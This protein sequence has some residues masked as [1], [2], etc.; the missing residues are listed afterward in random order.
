VVKISDQA[1]A[2]TGLRHHEAAAAGFDPVTVESAA[3]DHKACY[4]GSHRTTMRVTSDRATG[5]LPGMQVF[6]KRA[7]IAER[8]DI[9]ASAIYGTVTVDPVSDPDLSYAPPPGSPCDAVQ[10]GRAGLAPGYPAA[11][12]RSGH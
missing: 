10:R 8:I 1:A 5:R 6:G 4:P 11:L 3:D 2:R 12:I 7:T 9:A